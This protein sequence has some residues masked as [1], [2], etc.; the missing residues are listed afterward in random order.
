MSSLMPERT[1]PPFP[2]R[3]HGSWQRI[4]LA[5]ARYNRL[6][7]YPTWQWHSLAMCSYSPPATLA[8]ARLTL[9][10]FVR[11]PLLAPPAPVRTAPLDDAD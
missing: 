6:V 3:D 5:S 7:A 4:G 10:L 11:H 9:S 1:R 2:A 8:D